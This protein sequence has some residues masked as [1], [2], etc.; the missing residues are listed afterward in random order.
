MQ[1]VSSRRPRSRACRGG[2][3]EYPPPPC[4]AGAGCRVGVAETAAEA[5]A[6][7]TAANAAP[8]APPSDT[9]TREEVGREEGETEEG[10]GPPDGKRA[11]VVVETSKLTRPPTPAL[12]NPPRG[13]EGGVREEEEAMVTEE[14]AP[15]D[16]NKQLLR[17]HPRRLLKVDEGG[18]GSVWCATRWRVKLVK[19]ARPPVAI[20]FVIA[21]NSVKI[22]TCGERTT[23]RSLARLEGGTGARREPRNGPQGRIQ[24]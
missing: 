18:V 4:C 2:G 21:I 16:A 9:G 24:A 12:P 20:L 10:P 1:G 8:A 6:A 15:G 3:V 19:P 5:T 23:D 17:W 14:K 7:G 13:E 11:L 22:R